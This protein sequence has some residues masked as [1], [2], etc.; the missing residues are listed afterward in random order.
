MSNVAFVSA[1]SVVDGSKVASDTSDDPN[2]AAADDKTAVSITATPSIE[3][4]KTASVNDPD[5]NG[6]DLGDTITYTIV[7]TNTGDLTLSNIKLLI[8]LPMQIAPRS[9]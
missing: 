7:A 8:L 6:V 1:A 5:S 4:T 3:V 2:T 9:N